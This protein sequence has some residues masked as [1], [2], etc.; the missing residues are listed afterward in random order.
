M[1]TTRKRIPPG[2]IVVGDPKN[3]TGF[4]IPSG[5]IDYPGGEYEVPRAI[6]VPEIGRPQPYE[7]PFQPMAQK[8]DNW[9]FSTICL[10]V[11]GFGILIIA[12]ISFFIYFF[13]NS[14]FEK[15]RRSS[16]DRGRSY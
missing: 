1:K 3:P 11:F 7:Q 9:D 12:L 15:S 14:R 2:A 5:T 8:N 13:G 6:G 16:R 4:M 10:L